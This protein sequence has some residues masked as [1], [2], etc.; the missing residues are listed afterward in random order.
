MR[1]LDS[2]IVRKEMKDIETLQKKVYGNVFNFPNMST[3][4]KILHIECLEELLEKFKI[5]FNKKEQ[6]QVTELE[7]LIL[8]WNR[9][10][11]TT[12]ISSNY[13]INSHK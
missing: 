11:P 7:G 10:L 8:S 3:E 5:F 13:G 1:F 2:E 4:D 9:S 12:Y 6:L